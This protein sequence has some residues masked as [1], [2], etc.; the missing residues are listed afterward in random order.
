MVNKTDYNTKI[1]ETEKKVAD[2]NHDK[3]VTIADFNKISAE[4]FDVKLARENLARKNFHDKRNSQN[5]KI[6][7]N[8]TKHL[9]VETEFKKL[10]IFDSIYF[11]SKI[12]WKKMV[13]KIAK[14]FSQCTDILKGLVVLVLVIISFYWKS[15][16]LS[17]ENITAPNT[18][19][20]KFNPQ[21]SY[22]GTKTRIEFS[23]SC[24][25]QYKITHDRCF[26]ISKK[27]T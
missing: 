24:L 23:G 27:L 18:S 25:K 13:Q 8:K 15:K 22:F 21:L 19:D 12:H 6:N 2:Y 10:Q 7:L 5:Q 20:Y 26:E 17:N 11:R 14:Y 4:I 3:Y 9:L 1:K 16:G